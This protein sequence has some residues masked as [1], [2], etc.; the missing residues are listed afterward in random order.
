[1]LTRHR[2]SGPA[3]L[4][5]KCW[6]R[7]RAAPQLAELL[8]MGSATAI[9]SCCQAHGGPELESLSEPAWVS[10]VRRHCGSAPARRQRHGQSGRARCLISR[11]SR[12][13]VNG[14]LIITG[15]PDLWGVL[16]VSGTHLY[17]ACA[18]RLT[19]SPARAPRLPSGNEGFFN[20]PAAHILTRKPP[21]C[22]SRAAIPSKPSLHA[23]LDIPR[24]QRAANRRHPD[25][26]PPLGPSRVPGIPVSPAPRAAPATR[27]PVPP[28]RPR[29]RPH[30][31]TPSGSRGAALVLALELVGVDVSFGIPGGARAPGLRPLSTRARFM[32]TSSPCA[33]RP[34]TRHGNRRPRCAPA[35]LATSGRARPTWSP[36]SPTAH[37]LR[38]RSR[39][40]HPFPRTIA[41]TV[42]GGGTSPGSPTRSQANFLCT[43]P[44]DIGPHIG[45]A[46]H[47][48][49]PGPRAPSL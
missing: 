15:G 6:P 46:I 31:A 16:S 14:T 43:K 32:H 42:P 3:T 19:S 37:G 49:P 47:L 8:E 22:P 24:G 29:P 48:A 21:R 18:Q 25:R 36:R 39:D 7:D 33:G 30:H 41:P 23:P 9:A 28:A 40:H 45:E 34:G 2:A 44:E 20:A 11:T 26:P 27:I 35:W 12:L 5:C 38:A 4:A 17:L 10:G 1:M 13:D